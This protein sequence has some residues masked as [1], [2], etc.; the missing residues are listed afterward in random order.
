MN[1]SLAFSLVSSV[2]P[3]TIAT[4]ENPTPAEPN[5]ELVEMDAAQRD[6]HLDSVRLRVDIDE[7]GKPRIKKF[8]G[9]QAELVSKCLRSKESGVFVQVKEIQTWPAS[10]VSG[11]YVAAQGLNHLTEKDPEAK[12]G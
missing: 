8:E 4:A 2:I 6:R 5:Y 3:V 10:I 12:N 1:Q 7:G 9:L 11:L